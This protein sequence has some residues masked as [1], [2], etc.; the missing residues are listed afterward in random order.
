MT[1]FSTVTEQPLQLATRSQM[2]MLTTRYAWAVERAQGREVL[3]VACGAGLGLAWLA[4][5]ALSVEAGDIDGH[6]CKLAKEGCP[7][8]RVHRMDASCLPFPDS[9]FD[10]VVLF[11]AIYYLPDAGLFVREAHRVLRP[12]GRLLVSSVNREWTGFNPSPFSTRY[13]SAAELKEACRAHGFETGLFAGFPEG[14]G[15]VGLVRQAAIFLGWVPATMR[16]KAFLKRVFYGP[17]ERIT[18]RIEATRTEP[19]APIDDRLDLT[20]YRVL[21]AEARRK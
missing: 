1:D 8:V 21:Y 10:L 18:G 4:S 14:R 3:E 5:A 20:R 16:G 9:S 15:L 2:A 6:N 17:L 11:E 13:F 7:K 19:L 12:G